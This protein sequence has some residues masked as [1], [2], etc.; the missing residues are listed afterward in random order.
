MAMMI[1]SV[2]IDSVISIRRWMMLSD[3]AAHQPGNAAED[4]AEHQ[5]EGHADQPDA[6]RNAAAE[7]DAAEDIAPAFIRAHQVERLP[8]LQRADQVNV[9]SDQAPQFVRLAM[10]EQAQ[11]G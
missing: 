1:G 3:E 11:S 8:R 9:G 7:D 5:A 6:Q 2:G 4:D 10:N